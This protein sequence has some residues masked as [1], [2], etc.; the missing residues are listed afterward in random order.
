MPVRAR[1]GQPSC[2]AAQSL[3]CLGPWPY[4]TPLLCS[5][6]SA[7]AINPG[8][9]GGPVFNDAGEVVGLAFQS[10][11]GAEGIGYAVPYEIMAHF[12][13]DVHL[14]GSFTGFPDL[15]LQ[16]QRT[17][18]P[19]LR[20]VMIG[21]VGEP[22]RRLLLCDC[23]AANL[24][25]LWQPGA[26]GSWAGVPAHSTWRRLSIPLTPPHLPCRAAYNMSEGQQGLLVRQ[27]E[28]LGSC[29]GQVQE[30]DVLTK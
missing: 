28:P 30:G 29:A 1:S 25:M 9:S 12:F 21:L 26:G 2:R 23:T 3:G 15:G 7:A 17:E 22:S 6:R 14:N 13:Q 18:S 10:L 16:L 19:A 8:N 27:V 11:N 20:W 4:R 24:I 5:A